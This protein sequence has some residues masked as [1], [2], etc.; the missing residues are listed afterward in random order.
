MYFKQ[1]YDPDLAQGSYLIGCQATGEAVVVDPRRDAHVYLAAA[2]EQGLRVT[3]VTDTHIHADYVSGAREL[4]AASG[5]TLY[6]SDEGGAPD[7]PAGDW[8]YRFE[9]E[10]LVH[11]SRLRVG[12]VELEALHTPGHT[13]EHLSFLVTDTARSHHPSHL[14]TGDFVFVGDLGRP[15]LLDAVAGGEGTRFHGATQLFKGLKDVFLA[16][17]DHVQVWPGHGAG[18]VCGRSL[19]AVP[20]TTVGYER[21]TAWWGPFVRQW[22]EE[23]F[24]KEL[25]EGQPEAPD[26]F[27]RMKRVNRDGPPLRARRAPLRRFTGEELR[28]RVNRDLVLI[29]TRSVRE[30]WEGSVRGALAVPGGESFATYAAWAVDP[31]S[32]SRPIVLVAKDEAHARRLVDRLSYVGIDDVIGYV[33]SLEGLE[34]VP[35]PL[36]RPE[37]L[38]ELEGAEV[39]DV[40]GAAE[41]ALGHVP[42]ARQLAAGN[43]LAR[44]HQLP[45]GGKL[46]LYC[47][48]GGRSAVIASALRARGFSQVFEVDGSFDAW[49]ERTLG[50]GGW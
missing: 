26:Y 29:D 6:L 24:V 47:Q 48:S 5:A 12:N 30:Q 35:V 49:A 17:P 13:P 18:S 8:L 23:G 11:R 20:S 4:A 38:R 37:E 16:L 21:L 25:L 39:V 27:A 15:D 31:D 3:A 2:A 22:D 46:V 33:A 19:G 9:H 43:A 28:G 7:S 1:F 32:E 44:S 10:G 14:L 36:V 40:R 45:R 41:Y 50:P 42:G 34:L